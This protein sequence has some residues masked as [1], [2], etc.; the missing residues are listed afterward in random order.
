MVLM[1]DLL[2]ITT[3]FKK[4]MVCMHGG[5]FSIVFVI[6]L[7]MYV[8]VWLEKNNFWLWKSRSNLFQKSTRTKQWE[9]SFLLK[10][11]TWAFDGAGSPNRQAATYYRSNLLPTVPRR[12]WYSKQ[13]RAILYNIVLKASMSVHYIAFDRLCMGT[14]GSQ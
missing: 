5:V 13:N 1:E 14:S 10:E 11:K 9:L 12:I 3:I 8:L 6:S 7:Y 2:K 4:K